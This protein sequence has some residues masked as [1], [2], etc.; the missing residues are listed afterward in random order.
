MYDSLILAK[1]LFKDCKK[2]N[3][4]ILLTLHR[5]YNTDNFSRL[6]KILDS[7][8]KLNFQVFFPVHPR[9]R[10]LLS[11]FNFDEGS[12]SNIHFSEP[13]PYFDF[14]KKQIESEIII[15]DSGGVQKEAYWLKK[16]CITIRSETEWTETLI[17]GWNSL[18][19]DDFHLISSVIKRK[20]KF[21]NKN[22]YGNGKA[23]IKIGDILNQKF[24]NE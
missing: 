1:N 9:T 8:N 5:P 20:S 2:I 16:K 23:T 18:I 3:K 14:V 22:L 15:T 17:G 4:S 19:F 6:I 12:Y 7:L 24:N 13:L 11:S 21:Y 10:K